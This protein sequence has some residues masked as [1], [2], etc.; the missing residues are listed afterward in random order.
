MAAVAAA[1]TIAAA[2]MPH[3]AMRVTPRRAF[4]YLVPSPILDR[5]RATGRF[6]QQR[7]SMSLNSG[8][9]NAGAGA[10][11][12]AWWKDGLSFSCTMCGHCC[13]GSKG[14]VKISAEEALQMAQKLG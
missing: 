2:C 12:E 6:A 10:S 13:S 1:L 14:S 9:I 4:A 8:E 5:C 7:A 3:G 11:G